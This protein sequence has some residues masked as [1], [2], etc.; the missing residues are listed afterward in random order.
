VKVRN[1]PAFAR[2][3]AGDLADF[4][5]PQRCSGCG[6]PADPERFLCEPC[7]ARIPPLETALCVRCLAG[8]GEGAPCA[9]HAAY[10]ARARWIYDERAALIVQALKYEER[11]GLARALGR[12][13][14]SVLPPGY[15]PELVIEVP[16]HPVRLRERGYNQAALL[17]D[18]VAAALNAPRP[19]RALERVRPTKAQA[20]LGPAARRANLAGAFRLVNPDAWRGRTVLVIDDVLTTGATLEAC[21]APLAKAG[22]RASALALAWAQ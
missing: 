7:L 12:R 22:A 4:V 9:R 19:A 8:G 6:A 21:L 14:A 15:R 11:P 3:L 18:A 17:A 5:W 2:R 16:L 10:N 1:A 20:R 13:M